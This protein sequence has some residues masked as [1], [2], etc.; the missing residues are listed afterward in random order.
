MHSQRGID[1]GLIGILKCMRHERWMMAREI[2]SDSTQYQ[3]LL[4]R[5]LIR[6][7]DAQTYGTARRYE[8][9]ITPRGLMILSQNET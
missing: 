1:E 5:G 2:G 6:R 7:R 9:L 8:Y 3:W 4:R